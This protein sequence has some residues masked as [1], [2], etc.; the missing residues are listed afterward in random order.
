MTL[1][2]L[3]DISES[4]LAKYQLH[5]FYNPRWAQTQMVTSLSYAKEWLESEPCVVTY[6]DIFYQSSAIE[7]LINS[8]AEI[9]VT[10]DPDWEKMCSERFG[11][12]LLDAETFQIDVDKT[13]KEIGGTPKSLQE[14]R[15]GP[16]NLNTPISGKPADQSGTIAL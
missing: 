12:P 11:D 13:V 7:L 4:Q 5:E 2:L 16:G 14:I 9:A 10:Y 1:Q 8:S 3:M 6:S 15:G